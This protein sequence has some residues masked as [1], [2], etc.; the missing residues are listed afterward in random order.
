MPT[1]DRDRAQVVLGRAESLRLLGSV[2]IGRLAYTQAALPAILPVSFSLHDDD[3]LI[4]VP[5]DSPLIDQLRG[6]VV[7]FEADAYDAAVRTGW[8]VAVIG[9][10]RL[11]AGGRN[12]GSLPRPSVIAVRVGLVQ[13][14]RTGLPG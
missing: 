14:L 10:S 3:V 8:T 12:D 2:G 6:S 4:Q 7:A 5:G 11:L 13:G 9:A 1:T